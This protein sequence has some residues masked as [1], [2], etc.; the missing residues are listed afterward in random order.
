MLITLK[1]I[2]L[3]ILTLYLLVFSIEIQ[4]KNIIFALDELLFTI[5]KK[6]L[7][8]ILG[9][10]NFS[11]KLGFWWYGGYTSKA[12]LVK[13]I[14][15]KLKSIPSQRILHPEHQA[16]YAGQKAAPI[17]C[18]WILG[19]RSSKEIQSTIIA[20]LTTI[21]LDPWI[22]KKLLE[23]AE[24]GLDPQKLMPV[25]ETVPEGVELLKRCYNTHRHNLY[26]LSNCPNE[27]FDLLHQKYA[28]LFALFSG[29]AV[30]GKI[31]LIKP[32]MPMYHYLLN[33][34]N[35]SPLDCIYIGTTPDGLIPAQQLGMTA[36]LWDPYNYA[37]G[38]AKLNEMKILD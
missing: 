33:T 29:W 3:S 30:S 28:D 25:I 5:D 35:L 24:L 11:T 4:S 8:D 19:F 22:R 37:P 20:H 23:M 14:M 6:T 13:D 36:I 34:Y 10:E 15:D 32:H 26:I 9:H 18:E 38:L 31:N 1:K 7:N 27:I 12:S 21:S 17:L 2:V 16:F